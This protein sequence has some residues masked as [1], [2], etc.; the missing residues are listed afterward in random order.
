MRPGLP[1]TFL[2]SFALRSISIRAI[3]QPALLKIMAHLNPNVKPPDAGV[4]KMR[5]LIGQ[6]GGGG[7]CARSYLTFTSKY[8]CM[9][10]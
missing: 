7:W 5:E 1:T 3:L 9:R 6:H 8:S 4:L 10:L 2:R